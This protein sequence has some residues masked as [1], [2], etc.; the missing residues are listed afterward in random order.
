MWKKIDWVDDF[1]DKS[2]TRLFLNKD[3]KISLL[4]LLYKNKHGGKE[5]MI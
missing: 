3:N 4:L 5:N 2:G 1:V